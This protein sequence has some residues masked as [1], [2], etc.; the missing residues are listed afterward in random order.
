MKK[1]QLINIIRSVIKEQFRGAPGGTTAFGKG[2]NTF[3]KDAQRFRYDFKSNLLNKF[4][5]PG[6][7]RISQIQGPQKE[8][9][10]SFISKRIAALQAKMDNLPMIPT[11]SGQGQKKQSPRYQQQLYVKM[12]I[13]DK[14]LEKLR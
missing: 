7:N 4:G 6:A 1:S 11:P 9:A 2:T 10:A 8:R 5:P 3:R 12:Q 14:M 13:S